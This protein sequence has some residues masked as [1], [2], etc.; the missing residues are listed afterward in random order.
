ML[1]ENDVVSALCAYLESRSWKIISRAHT[2]QHGD[3]IVAE[4]EGKRLLIEAKGGTSSRAGSKRFGQ[5]FHGLQAQHHVA[6]AVYKALKLL[7]ESP[8]TLVAIALPDNKS[9]RTHVERVEPALE[10]LG[11]GAFWVSEDGNVKVWGFRGL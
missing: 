8:D 6:E 5:P 4:H 10:R 11:I 1:T 9:H 2:S 3:D 7:S